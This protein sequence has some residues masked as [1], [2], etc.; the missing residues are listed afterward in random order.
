MF[1]T[2]PKNLVKT[3]LVSIQ[4]LSQKLYEKSSLM[5][6]CWSSR[7]ICSISKSKEK[8][9]THTKNGSGNKDLT[10]WR[11]PLTKTKTVTES[12]AAFFRTNEN[13][14]NQEIPLNPTLPNEHKTTKAW[15]KSSWSKCEKRNWKRCKL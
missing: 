7:F 13:H 3:K 2:R 12:A 1:I 9:T 8:S 10:H 15:M 4:L 6:N 14:L 11:V 5:I